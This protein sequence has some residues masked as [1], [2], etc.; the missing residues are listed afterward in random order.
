VPRSAPARTRATRGRLWSINVVN[1]LYMGLPFFFLPY[2][3]HAREIAYFAI[4]YRITNV[5]QTASVALGVYFA[6]RFA[7]AERDR[8]ERDLRRL[9]H[10]SQIASV[11]ILAPL[12][13]FLTPLGPVALRLFGSE[14]AGAWVYL[15]IPTAAR[16][17][18]AGCGLTEQF[19]AMT[20]NESREVAV[21]S[22]ALVVLAVV[23]FAAVRSYGTIGLCAA[24][25]GV[26]VGKFAIAC[27]V[28][29]MVLYHDAPL[30]S[31]IP[32]DAHQPSRT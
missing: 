32:T 6:P 8:D 16:L 29:L 12:A 31:A 15:A 10:A 5:A 23:S 28:S 18:I 21:S 11:A 22:V 4:G 17:L 14:F 2:F 30:D 3:A 19:L 7:R 27:L 1:A 25:Y 26:S 13:V 20:H 9:F 24:F